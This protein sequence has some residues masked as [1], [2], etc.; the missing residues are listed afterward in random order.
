MTRILIAVNEL[1][2]AH[3]ERIEAAVDGWATCRRIPQEAPREQYIKALSN[4]EIVFGWPQP[5]LLLESG[6]KFL[7]L[8]SVGVDGYLNC[9]LETMQDFRLCNAR[10]VMGVAMAEHCIAMMF[11]LTRRVAMH[12][13]DQ[14]RKVWR[15]RA[16]YREVEGAS[17]CVIGL[18]DIGGEIARRLK[19]L[20]MN[21]HAVSASSAGKGHPHASPVFPPE[22]LHEALA[23]ADHVVLIRPSMPDGSA[24]LG[25]EEF[26]AMKPG[27]FFYNVARGSL[28]DEGALVDALVSG[29]LAGAG[30]DVFA[31]E[32]LPANSPL[33]EMENVIVTP[34]I[35]GRSVGEFDRMCDLFVENLR[36]YHSGEDLKHRVELLATAL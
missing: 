24:L 29:H 25:R 21:V 8:P 16:P 17:A 36:R 33:W 32:S 13:R 6:V 11:A 27:A 18:G 34:H 15:K 19:G 4:S 3:M 2:P 35:A 9:G 5:E 12:L 30:L 26:A 14:E 20:G 10:G 28:V 7:Q 31:E 23:M 22:K 1:S